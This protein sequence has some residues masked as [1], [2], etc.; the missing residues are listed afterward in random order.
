[1]FRWRIY[2]TFPF[3]TGRYSQEL[4]LVWTRCLCNY[5]FN[6][7]LVSV[8]GHISKSNEIR[9]IVAKLLIC[10][11]TGLCISWLGINSPMLGR[12]KIFSILF[13]FTT[14]NFS[15][16]LTSALNLLYTE[17]KFQWFVVFPC[18]QGYIVFYI[19]SHTS[20]LASFILFLL[21][22]HS[23]RGKKISS[24]FYRF[25]RYL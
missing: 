10:V 16:T 14:D 24:H 17:I 8:H 20:L 2:D 18:D 12:Y 1:M 5:L 3:Y 6:I 9:I 22:P 7:W 19:L 15:Y 23:I 4:Q 25:S 21:I 11:Y 13:Y